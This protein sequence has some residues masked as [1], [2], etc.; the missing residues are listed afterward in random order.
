MRVEWDTAKDCE[1]QSDTDI[2]YT[3]SS[4]GVVGAEMAALVARWTRTEKINSI[5]KTF[6]FVLRHFI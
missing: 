3:H 6:S 1:F 4:S 2:A 5:L